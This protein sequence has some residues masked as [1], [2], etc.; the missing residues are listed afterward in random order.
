MMIDFVIMDDY[1][2]KIFLYVAAFPTFF[3]RKP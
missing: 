2:F 3:I 1:K